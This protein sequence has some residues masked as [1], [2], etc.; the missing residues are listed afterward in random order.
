MA[1]YYATERTESSMIHDDTHPDINKAKQHLEDFVLKNPEGTP[2]SIWKSTP[3]DLGAAGPGFELYFVFLKQM[4]LLFTILTVACLP[5]M[6]LNFTGGYLH[7]VETTSPFESST[8]G[9][10]ESLPDKLL[11]S[12]D[13]RATISNHKRK[14]HMTM[15]IDMAYVI[16]YIV[17]VTL[18]QCYS[19]KRAR[20][21]RNVIV[22]DFSI[23]VEL[24]KGVA[25]TE[26]E[27]R[28]FFE[29]YGPV[30]E[31]CIP[32][33]YGK[34]LKRYMKFNA[35]EK[36]LFTEMRK[37]RN[38]DNAD[39]LDK[40]RTKRFE[41]LEKLK[42]EPDNSNYSVKAFIIFETIKS[43]DACLN[44][45]AR[46]ER[47]DG[48]KKQPQRLRFK[49]SPIIV[50]NAA[51]PREMKWESFGEKIIH[52]K[53]VLIYIILLYSSV[54]ALVIISIVEYYEIRLPTYK[55]CIATLSL[56]ENNPTLENL[57]KNNQTH[58]MCF[59]GGYSEEEIKDKSDYD[60]FC[61]NY[62]TYFFM[63]WILR[64]C[65]IGVVALLDKIVKDSLIG[66]FMVCR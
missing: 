15:F 62:S 20:T 52:W 44:D 47:F 11:D 57:D 25:A 3:A 5:V 66:N 21:T 28:S 56:P 63:I 37:S 55:K 7:K 10:Q 13:P 14:M 48:L 34:V 9:N 31:S 38:Q 29:K 1:S 65:G 24:Q 22:S 12:D 6:I 4:I 36:E 18:F 41:F 16:L 23:L 26:E 2:L 42:A 61:T 19:Y 40:I 51:D 49:N 64:F 8:L 53:S 59:C 43:R 35:I 45:Y 27:L 58:V 54:I 60:E 39:K 17:L 30:H 33:Y 32:K 50:Q 46:S